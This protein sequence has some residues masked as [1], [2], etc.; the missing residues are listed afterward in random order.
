MSVANVKS[1]I[2]YCALVQFAIVMCLFQLMR[3]LTRCK[4]RKLVKC[5]DDN[6]VCCSFLKCFFFFF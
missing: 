1:S 4:G 2:I 5:G 3:Q 6:E